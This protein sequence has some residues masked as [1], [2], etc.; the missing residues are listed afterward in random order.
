[1]RTYTR[2]LLLVMSTVT[3]VS[4]DGSQFYVLMILYTVNGSYTRLVLFAP[5]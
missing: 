4:R 1:M 3:P 2:G 5:F